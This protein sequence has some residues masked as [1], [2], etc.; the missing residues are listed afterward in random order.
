MMC[1]N[2]TFM[3]NKHILKQ[4]KKPKPIDHKQQVQLV[5]FPSSHRF[6]RGLACWAVLHLFIMLQALRKNPPQTL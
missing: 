2:A 4:G 5:P 3:S 6:T 1:G